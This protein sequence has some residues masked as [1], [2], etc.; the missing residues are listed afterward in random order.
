MSV[1]I[2]GLVV[3]DPTVDNAPIVTE[4]VNYPAGAIDVPGGL[5]YHRTTIDWG[6]RIGGPVVRGAGATQS[7][8]P[9]ATK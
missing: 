9:E 7:L 3:D 1:A 4:A 5:I 8:L 6:R 2:E